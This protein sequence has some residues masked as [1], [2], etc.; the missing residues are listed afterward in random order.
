[1]AGLSLIGSL[2][3][4]VMQ[5]QGAKQQA[6]AQKAAGKAQQQ[7]LNYE[8]AQLDVRAKQEQAAAQQEGQEIGR[9]KK[10]ALSALQARSAAGGFTATDPTAL[11]LAGEIESYGTLQEQMAAFGGGDRRAGI[12][13]QAEGRRLSG[14]AARQGANLAARGT[15]LGGTSS[16][17]SKFFSGL[18]SGGGGGST[19]YR[20]G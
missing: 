16:M 19:S 15:I 14:R 12:E 1:M 6:A 17:F 8:A 13:A 20:Y 3:G 11:D 4:G 2:I 18:P 5:M 9:R 7:Q 10:L